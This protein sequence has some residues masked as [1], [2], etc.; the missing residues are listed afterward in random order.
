MRRLSA[1]FLQCK[2]LLQMWG[3]HSENLNITWKSMKPSLRGDLKDGENYPDNESEQREEGRKVVQT[4]YHQCPFSSCHQCPFPLVQFKIQLKKQAYIV[5]RGNFP[6]YLLIP[7]VL[8]FQ[9]LV[10]II[11]LLLLKTIGRACFKSSRIFIEL[12]F[13]WLPSICSGTWR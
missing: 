5:R 6:Y 13:L 11:G 4:K 8:F 2:L 7:L 9:V 12:V 1:E 3:H 10:L